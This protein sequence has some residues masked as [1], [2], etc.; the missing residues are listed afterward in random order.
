MFLLRLKEAFVH[1]HTSNLIAI[2]VTVVVLKLRA[3]KVIITLH[4]QQLM[5]FY[6]STSP[7][8]KRIVRS[9]LGRVSYIICVNH[10]LK[11]WLVSIGLNESRMTVSPAFIPPSKDE[12]DIQT[13]PVG[14]AEFLASH[15]PII[16]THGWFGNFVDGVHVYSFD[17]IVELIQRLLAILPEAGFYTTIS[18]TYDKQHRADVYN[19]RKN[20]LLEEKWLIIEDNINAVPLYSRTS[21]FVRP[22]ITDGDSVSI[23]ECLFLGVPVVASDA[24]KRPEG[25]V[26]FKNRDGEALLE[27]VVS[28]LE[29]IDSMRE[30]IKNI[31]YPDPSDSVVSVYRSALEGAAPQ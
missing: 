17:M 26:I 8:M 14:A 23:R 15:T 9:S 10:A 27:A 19:Q 13:L 16:G 18:G 31:E 28:S 24:V 4:N 12:I 11:E 20:L 2:A 29:N 30:K 21:L 7:F 3:R 25:C 22:T 1:I 6:R 5:T